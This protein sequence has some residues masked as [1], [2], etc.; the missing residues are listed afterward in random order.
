[1]ENSRVV[2]VDVDLRPH[3]VYTP[4][5]WDRHNLA[6][7]VASVVLC[8]IFYDLY[9]GSRATILSFQS[10]ESILAIIAL[11]VLFIL[12]ALLLFPYLRVRAMFR[13]SPALT[14][15]RRYTFGTTGVAIHSEDATS[16]CRWSLFQRAVETPSVFVFS[17]TLRGGTYIPK[18]CFAS[19]DDIVRLRDL[20]RENMPGK[21]KLRP[22]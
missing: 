11:L 7:W 14:K 22:A 6:R 10:G 5:R 18:R 17:Q 8:Y 2:V 13:K 4:F 16:D 1:M 21:C 12:S 9:E 15:T 20:I 3:D 19:S